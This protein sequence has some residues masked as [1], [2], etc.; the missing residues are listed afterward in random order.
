MGI[1]A[2]S[3]SLPPHLHDPHTPYAKGQPHLL[4]G[5]EIQSG[6]WNYSPC[7]VHLYCESLSGQIARA[8]P[9][10]TCTTVSITH[11]LASRCSQDPAIGMLTTH[12]PTQLLCAL[13]GGALP[14]SPPGSSV[15]NLTLFPAAHGEKL[16]TI[17][18]HP[19]QVVHS[20]WMVI[21][22]CEK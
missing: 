15:G 3:P 11:W 18:C 16:S 4:T 7:S 1:G 21:P 9:Q 10:A 22:H 2:Q 5:A 20:T 12:C 14:S 8:V 19:G 17:L 6:Q 13:G